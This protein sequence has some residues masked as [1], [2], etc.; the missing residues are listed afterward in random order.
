MAS[1]AEASTSS[2]AFLSFLRFFFPSCTPSSSGTCA[3]SLAASLLGDAT[4][5]FSNAWLE[6]FNRDCTKDRSFSGKSPPDTPMEAACFIPAFNVALRV[7]AFLYWDWCSTISAITAQATTW[8]ALERT[9][10][11]SVASCFT[12]LWLHLATPA[13]CWM[14]FQ[15][16]CQVFLLS[17]SLLMVA[18][19]SG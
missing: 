13:I 16:V 12:A 18:S 19:T 3:A 9:W 8:A 17:G 5:S 11:I 14:S 10:E 6:A 7:P 4:E 2:V 1:G 15:Y